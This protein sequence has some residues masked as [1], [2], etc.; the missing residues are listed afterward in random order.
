MALVSVAMHDV[1]VAAWDNKYAYNRP[2]PGERDASIVPR[3]TAPLSP[4]FPSEHAATG[5][6]AAAVLAYLFP[7]S[8]DTFRS[9]AEE[10]ARSRLFAG[11]QYP[12]DV[13]AGMELGAKVGA[14][15]VAYAKADG[16]DVSL[17]RHSR[18]RM[19]YGATPI[20]W[21]RWPDRGAHG[22]SRLPTKCDWILHPHSGR[23]RRTRNMPR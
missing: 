22:H 16:S 18:Q 15:V 7:D 8:A 14:A 11:T 9:L 10:D 5:A 20:R 17:R 19:E 4:S 21:R 23:P 2:R 6:A 3:V 12:S 1:T 13:V